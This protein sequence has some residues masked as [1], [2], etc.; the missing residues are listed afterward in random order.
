MR[1]IDKIIVHCSASQDSLDIGAKEINEWHKQRGWSGIGYHYVIRRDGTIEVGRP[2]HKMGAHCKGQNRASI[3]VCWVGIDNPTPEQF[4]SMDALLAD[5]V[6]IYD[7]NI[8]NVLGHREATVTSKTCP[9][10]DMDAI[11]AELFFSTLGGE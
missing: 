3:G 7:V 2:V 4:L 5:L 1:F 10:I 6:R 9:N 11:R 8:D